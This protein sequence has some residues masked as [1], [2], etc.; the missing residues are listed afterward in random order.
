MTAQQQNDLLNILIDNSYLSPDN[1]I[2]TCITLNNKKY[3]QIVA[4]I[5]AFEN[6]KNP[7]SNNLLKTIIE[8]GWINCNG[9]IWSSIPSR[10]KHYEEIKELIKE[11]E[12]QWKLMNTLKQN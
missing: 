1:T 2:L 7:C 11:N 9:T 6:G 3:V 4:M 8:H 12:R 10:N 5:V